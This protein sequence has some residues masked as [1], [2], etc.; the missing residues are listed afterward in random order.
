MWSKNQTFQT[1]NSDANLGEGNKKIYVY[2]VDSL[3]NVS[4]P[5]V[6][7]FSVDRSAPSITNGQYQQVQIQFI[8]KE[9]TSLRL[10]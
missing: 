6:R 7:E 1:G 2:A 10:I 3:G 9:L 8:R 5:A 4:N